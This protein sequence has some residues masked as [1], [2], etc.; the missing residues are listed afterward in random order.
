MGCERKR[1]YKLVG[2]WVLITAQ[3][4]RFYGTNFENGTTVAFPIGFSGEAFTVFATRGP[5]Q[6]W[7]EAAVVLSMTKTGAVIAQRYIDNAMFLA[8][9][10]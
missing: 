2:D 9:G 6:Y 1:I 7:F 3:W 8:V 10:I 5:S 4:G